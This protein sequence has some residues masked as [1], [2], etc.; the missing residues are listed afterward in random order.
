MKYS[1]SLHKYPEP[2]KEKLPDFQSNDDEF[3]YITCSNLYDDANSRIDSL[4]DKAFKLLSYVTALF[5]FISFVFV[6]LNFMITRVFLSLGVLFLFIAMMI[7]F[8]CINIKGRKK[9]FLPSIYNFKKKNPIDNFDRKKI[10]K[11]MLNSAIYNQNIADSTAD[12]LNGIRYAVIIA[13]IFSVIGILFGIGSYSNKSEVESINT[14]NQISIDGIED[15][16]QEQNLILKENI[17]SNITLEKDEYY[18]EKIK[19]INES[20]INIDNDLTDIL[21]KI[22]RTESPIGIQQ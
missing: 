7:S 22:E 12:I 13:I 20:L 21:D 1:L 11:E 15:K 5:A 4:E 8:R 19:E 18:E 14:N 17:N 9:I 16:L 2:P 3:I 6:N 10:S